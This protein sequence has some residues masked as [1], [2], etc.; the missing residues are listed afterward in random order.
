LINFVGFVNDA[1][2][3]SNM[4]EMKSDDI[5]SEKMIYEGHLKFDEIVLGVKEGRY[6]QGRMNVS[7]LV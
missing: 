1:E 3:E 2:T 7:R 6:F 4:E 5:D